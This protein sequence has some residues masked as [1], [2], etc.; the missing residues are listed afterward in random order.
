MRVRRRDR[1][2]PARSEAGP[3]RA[4]PLTGARLKRAS[5]IRY[6]IRATDGR[7]ICSNKADKIAFVQN[8]QSHPTPSSA[9]DSATQDTPPH[10]MA[11]E[12]GL[13]R[14][15]TRNTMASTV[16]PTAK[17]APLPDRKQHDGG[18]RRANT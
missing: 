13:G 10:G 5:A 11:V 18:S 6:M 9:P 8:Q 3:E 1:H 15:K 12:V 17:L 2:D 4:S 14:G 7:E 16:T